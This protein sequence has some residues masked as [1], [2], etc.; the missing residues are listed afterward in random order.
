MAV[1]S[2]VPKICRSP[3]YAHPR[4]TH[5]PEVR[6]CS[7][8]CHEPYVSQ[9]RLVAGR[10]SRVLHE[11][12]FVSGKQENPDSGSLSS[13]GKIVFAQSPY[14][15]SN[16]SNSFAMVLE[17][18]PFLY[19][20]HTKDPLN[21]VF[22]EPPDEHLP[23]RDQRYAFQESM[24]RMLMVLCLSFFPGP[25]VDFLPISDSQPDRP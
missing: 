1:L 24:P 8:V 12:V 15:N 11:V 23:H 20:K 2:P 3:R 19:S 13:V 25:H 21:T 6:L 7:L 16:P 22:V 14:E 10:N 9:T 5:V 18:T 4:G 17:R